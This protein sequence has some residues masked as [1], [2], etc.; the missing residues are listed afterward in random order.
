MCYL[1]DSIGFSWF[2]PDV[3]FHCHRYDGLAT[4]RTCP[5]GDEHRLSISGTRRR[6]MFAAGPAL[7]TGRVR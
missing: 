1:L 7:E 4:N 5:H 3:A 2:D 6:E